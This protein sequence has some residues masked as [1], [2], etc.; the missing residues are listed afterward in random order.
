MTSSRRERTM[1]ATISNELQ[2][3]ILDATE[4]LAR[5]E[6]ALS[7]ALKGLDGGKRADKRMVSEAVRTAFETLA[8]ARSQLTALLDSSRD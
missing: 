5:A 7:V 2:R 4:N 3:R 8:T 1:A 6:G